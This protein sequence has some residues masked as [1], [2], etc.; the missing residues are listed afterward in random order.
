MRWDVR[1]PSVGTARIK[2][3]FLLLPKTL[4]GECRWLEWVRV[5]QVWQ[6]Y[7]KQIKWGFTKTC[8]GWRDIDWVEQG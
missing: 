3:K 6:S 5:H 1:K 7:E 2:L 4:R 8:F